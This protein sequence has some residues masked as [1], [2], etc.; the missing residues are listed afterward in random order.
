M[1]VMCRNTI[2]IGWAELG[3]I[4]TMDRQTLSGVVAS[5]YQ[6]SPPGTKGLVANML[7]NFNNEIRPGDIVIARKGRKL[8]AAVG[9]V[10]KSGYYAP[11]KN[12]YLSATSD[13]HANFI[14][15]A[16]QATPRDKEFSNIVFPMHTVSESSANQYQTIV[17]GENVEQVLSP[18]GEPIEDRN[19]FVL[20]KYL[21]DFIVSN[22]AAIF[23]GEL[24]MYG[25]APGSD[26]QQYTTDIGSI[27]I[28]AI[29]PKT[30]SFVDIE[31][32]KGRPSDQVVGQ[33][34]R[35]MGWVNEKLC[36]KGQEVRGLIIC[37]EPDTRLNY[38]LSM[39]KNVA[40]KYYSVSFKLADAP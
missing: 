24:K 6:S 29:E 20:E 40:V 28:L 11:G 7:W 12:A 34:L 2:S 19:E 17:G 23:K 9:T 14:D 4:S 30:K 8:L 27:D 35:Y 36:D 13:P 15:V 3:D 32:K 22:F 21:E 1:G 38:A 5:K 31:L 26:G 33:V 37:R 10:T 25:D 16:W 39:T 18:V